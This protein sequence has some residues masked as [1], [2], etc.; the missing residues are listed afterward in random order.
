MAGESVLVV[1]DTPLNL[2]LLSVLPVDTR[3]FPTH[4]AE[5]L[6]RGRTATS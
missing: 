1:D 6:A 2:E 4:V 3:M 5:L